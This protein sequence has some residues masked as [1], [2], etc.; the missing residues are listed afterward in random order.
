[1]DTPDIPPKPKPHTPSLGCLVFVTRPDSPKKLWIVCQSMD[2]HESEVSVGF[3]MTC[4][5]PHTVRTEAV[6]SEGSPGMG[7]Q[8]ILGC[9][10]NLNPKPQL[11]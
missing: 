5:R 2:I 7:L 8:W 4:F 9:R 11:M 1:M 6:S 3:M 10:A